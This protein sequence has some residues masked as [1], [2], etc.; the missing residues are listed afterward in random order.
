MSS[1][2]LPLPCP[3]SLPLPRPWQLLFAAAAAFWPASAHGQVG[4]LKPARIEYEYFPSAGVSGPSS[5]GAPSEA[6]FQAA[7]A[8]LTLP[9][10]VGKSTL[11]LP[12]L[13]YQVLD[14]GQAGAQPPAGRDP[15]EALHSLQLSL[16][17]FQQL[18]EQW[19]MFGQVGG[20]IAGDLSGELSSDDWV[21]SATVLGLWTFE[22]SFTLGGGIGYDR[23]TGNVAPLPLIAVNWEP[24]S[25]VLLRGVLPQFVSLRY[26]PEEHLTLALDSGLDGERYHLSRELVVA[27]HA[28][29]AYSV[30]KV[31]PSVTLHWTKW[32]HTRLNG[33]MALH[34]RFDMY[35]DDR[36]QGDLDV[37]SGPYAGLELWLGPSGWSSDA[38]EAAL[39]AAGRAPDPRT[40]N[41]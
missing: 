10:P 1:V 34:R 30:I 38:A 27:D 16:G 9:A 13:R 7:R 11:L 32:L 14:V 26:R 6:R 31:G 41:D 36:S 29:V 35:L 20:G 15:V 39:A 37:S 40:P 3:R 5:G 33:G 21:V 8:S 17:V 2:A 23:R 4:E 22:H 24:S 28:E 25:N 12:A 19:S 18:G